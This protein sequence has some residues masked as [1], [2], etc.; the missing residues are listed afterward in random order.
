MIIGRMFIR[1]CV[2]NIVFHLCFVANNHSPQY[3]FVSISSSLCIAF[4]QRDSW[5]QYT[6]YDDRLAAPAVFGRLA[7]YEDT[8]DAEIS[9]FL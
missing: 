9:G 2:F 6:A 1:L 4:S 3:Q 7:G 5:R 8:N